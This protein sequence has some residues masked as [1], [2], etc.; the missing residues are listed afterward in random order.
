METSLEEFLK[1]VNI[2]HSAA[3]VEKSFLSYFAHKWVLVKLETWPQLFKSLDN[4][5][6]RINLYPVDNAIG[7]PNTYPLDSDLSGV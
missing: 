5:I 4:A 6:H 7:F 3:E 2:E 1:H